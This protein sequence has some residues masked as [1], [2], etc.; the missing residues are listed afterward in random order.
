VEWIGEVSKVLAFR[1]LILSRQLRS[2]GKS[3]D[4]GDP[5]HLNELKTNEN[6]AVI[7][8]PTFLIS[9]LPTQSPR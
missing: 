2:H 4:T 1:Q 3:P 5:N 7:S 9:S 6:V 8:Q